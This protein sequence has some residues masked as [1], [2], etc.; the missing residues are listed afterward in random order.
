MSAG[1]P[2]PHGWAL[3]R[4]AETFSKSL[5]AQLWFLSTVRLEG[6]REGG[7]QSTCCSGDALAL[8]GS[9]ARVSVGSSGGPR[10]CG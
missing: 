7:A 8:Q 9:W 6:A 10:G 3:R 1:I 5:G 4:L 2:G